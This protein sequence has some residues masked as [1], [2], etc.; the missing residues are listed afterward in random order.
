MNIRIERDN[1]DN[2]ILAIYVK[3]REGLVYRTV[4]IKEGACYADEDSGGNLLGIEV[5]ASGELR[6]NLKQIAERYPQEEDLSQSLETALESIP[7]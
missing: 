6:V 7:A 3:F 4:E 1:E 2:Q 5:L